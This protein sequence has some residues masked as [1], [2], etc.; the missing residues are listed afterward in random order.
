MSQRKRKKWLK[1]IKP[2]HLQCFEFTRGYLESGTYPVI[3]RRVFWSTSRPYWAEPLSK[4]IIK[5]PKL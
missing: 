1:K 2:E 4:L 3:Q 5:W